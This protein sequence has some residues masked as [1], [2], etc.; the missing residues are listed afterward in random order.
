MNAARFDEYT[1]IFR[2]RELNVLAEQIIKKVSSERKTIEN[3]FGL[4]FPTINN[5]VRVV[6]EP[7]HRIIEK[8]ATYRYTF[9]AATNSKLPPH[10]PSFRI[11]LQ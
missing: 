1:V 6:N 4:C 10:V 9:D 7:E 8:I 2:L 5:K 3:S 11:E